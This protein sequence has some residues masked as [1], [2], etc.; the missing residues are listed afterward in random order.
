MDDHEAPIM[1]AK[2]ENDSFNVTLVP[3]YVKWFENLTNGGQIVGDTFMR[4]SQT[5][6]ITFDL[7]VEST[8]TGAQ[9]EYGRVGDPLKSVSRPTNTVIPNLPLAVW[10]VRVSMTGYK[11]VT[12]EHDALRET[13]HTEKPELQIAALRR[14]VASP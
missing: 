2:P 5:R 11:P 9:V 10:I 14:I 13:E 4:V 1:K 6:I 7:R 3:R 12:I 8:P